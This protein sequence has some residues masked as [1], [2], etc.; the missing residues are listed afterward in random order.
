MRKFH[1]QHNHNL[2]NHAHKNLMLP[3]N[4]TFCYHIVEDFREQ[5]IPGVD[6]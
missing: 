3:Q 6:S 2:N 5:G 4:N 1:L